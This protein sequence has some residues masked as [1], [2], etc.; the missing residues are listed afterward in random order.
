MP[1]LGM[2]V[3]L[4]DSVCASGRGRDFDSKA[5]ASK[6]DDKPELGVWRNWYN[7]DYDADVIY[8]TGISVVLSAA[9]VNTKL[10]ICRDV[11]FRLCGN[12]GGCS[13]NMQWSG[14]M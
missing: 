2:S 13:L 7:S 11:I 3:Y 10:D 9:H 14:T 8:V 5:P 12:F 4:C 1:G 6:H